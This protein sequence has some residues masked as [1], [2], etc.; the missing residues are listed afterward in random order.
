MQ[1]PH[2][3][4]TTLALLLKNIY[5]TALLPYEIEQQL[6]NQ[7][8][9][10][11][12]PN[13]LPRS[14][15]NKPIL[16]DLQLYLVQIVDLDQVNQI[17][18]VSIWL[19]QTWTDQR[20]VW[21]PEKF[22]NVSELRKNPTEIWTPDITLYNSANG[23][24]QFAEELESQ[25]MVKVT[26]NGTISWTPPVVYTATCAMRLRYFPFDV[27]S[28]YLKFGSWVYD[29]RFLDFKVKNESE[30]I[31]YTTTLGWFLAASPIKR[32]INSY[33]PENNPDNGYVEVEFYFILKRNFMKY[34]INIVLPCI[35]FGFLCAM[36]FNIP[37]N[38]GERLTLSLSVLIAIS[39]Y[40]ILVADL[41]PKSTDETPVITVFIT[42]LIFLVV[43][44]TL[45][46]S[47]VL[48]LWSSK[49]FKSP[50]KIFM[51][52]FKKYLGPVLLFENNNLFKKLKEKEEQRK[53]AEKYFEDLKIDFAD[54]IDFDEKYCHFHFDNNQTKDKT[55]QLHQK[56]LKEAK[57]YEWILLLKLF[58][59]IAM[60]IYCILLI[61]STVWCL[62]FEH[63]QDTQVE[64]Y[65]KT[66]Y[67]E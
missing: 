50:P 45:V 57:K 33:D 3:L 64:E 20:L 2:L 44:S 47:L 54:E 6:N 30:K 26:S 11:Y 60:V 13:V 22:N 31:N 53:I 27:Q 38:S 58:D 4:I 65:M 19:D 66:I 42:I 24:F 51:K 56:S 43:S 1:K 63:Y 8:F 12:Y 23:K 10:N 41:I 39:V 48:R 5:A 15:Q 35:L 49:H 9:S 14:S 36:S 46:T 40:Q 29:N 17:I 32:Y 62:S 52:I 55:I 61:I 59:R 21:D 28:C 16:I 25:V 18:T 67:S 37:Y 34:V 7:L